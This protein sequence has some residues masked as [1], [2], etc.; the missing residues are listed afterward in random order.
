MHGSS[1]TTG[2]KRRRKNA[3]A[4]RWEKTELIIH[5]IVEH[6]PLNSCVGE[7]RLG[8]TPNKSLTHEGIGLTR[9]RVNSLAG[10]R[11]KDNRIPSSI[12][13]GAKNMCS[14]EQCLVRISHRI[15]ARLDCSAE[16]H[17]CDV[18]HHKGYQKC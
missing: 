4:S 12:S 17:N 14:A 16:R 5:S 13:F 3:R 9:S 2:I 10:I 11:S 1:A 8:G 15:F 7:V 18:R 6:R